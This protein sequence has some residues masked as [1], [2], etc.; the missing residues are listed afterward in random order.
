[1]DQTLVSGATINVQLKSGTNNFHGELYE[2]HTDNLLKARPYFLPT[3]QPLPKNLDN[4]F[5]G[6][7]G[8]PILRN[9]LFFFASYEGDL[10]RQSGVQT[11]TLPTAAM[12]AGD[13]MDYKYDH[14]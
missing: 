6:T 8:G 13:F 11:L 7:L 12:L 14:L 5:G 4:N 2:F 3:G 1:M 9:K 10:N